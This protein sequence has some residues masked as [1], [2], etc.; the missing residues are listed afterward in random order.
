MRSSRRG[1]PPPGDLAERCG[2]ELMER[3]AAL[4]VP[5]NKPGVLQHVQVLGDRLPAGGQA[6]LHGEAGA[7]LEERLPVP[8]HQ[9]VEDRS[10]GGVREGLEH[11]AH[12]ST[13]GKLRLARQAPVRHRAQVRPTT[14]S[15]TSHRALWA[16]LVS[17]VRSESSVR[18]SCTSSSMALHQLL[19][20]KQLQQVA[21]RQANGEHL[22]EK[23]AR[24]L[25]TAGEIALDDPD[26]ADVLAYDAARYSATALLAHQGLRPTT[27]GGHYAVEVAVRAQFDVGAIWFALGNHRTP[28]SGRCHDGSVGRWRPATPSRAGVSLPRRD[29]GEP[30]CAVRAAEPQCRTADDHRP[31]RPRIPTVPSC[32]PVSPRTTAR[33][34]VSSTLT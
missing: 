26:S 20:G 23:A 27:S 18:G 31:G 5:R 12:G 1:G 6:V 11:V 2:V 8:V 13:I 3:V 34:E 10:P 29:P 15:R 21:G 32:A 33:A 22:L 28:R 7:E 30:T 14:A 19:A 25:A 9:L 16:T 17:E 24:T 4:T